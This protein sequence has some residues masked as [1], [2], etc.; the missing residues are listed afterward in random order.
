MRTLAAAIALVFL[1][2]SSS[3]SAEPAFVP[4]AAPENALWERLAGLTLSGHPERGLQFEFSHSTALGDGK[5]R[6]GRF[7]V[8]TT[9]HSTAAI[10]LG[11]AAQPVFAHL[12]WHLLILNSAGDWRFHDRTGWGFVLDERHT[13]EPFDARISKGH[14]QPVVSCNLG[15]WITAFLGQPKRF[16]WDEASRSLTIHGD[17][18]RRTVAWFRTPND[19]E[20][21]GA[22]LGGL[23]LIESPTADHESTMH[24]A[25]IQTQSGASRLAVTPSAELVTQLNATPF[26]A[27]DLPTIEQAEISAK[28]LRAAADF[29]ELV[30][31]RTVV[32]DLSNVGERERKTELEK[33][34]R[35]LSLPEQVVLLL[36]MNNDSRKPEIT[37]RLTR[38]TLLLLQGKI[39]ERSQQQ[40]VLY[41]DDPA[42]IRA[43]VE[44]IL[45]H[46][47]AETLYLVCNDLLKNP[48]VSVSSKLQICS[49]L[50]EWGLPVW[51]TPHLAFKDARERSPL[52][53]GLLRA[54]WLLPCQADHVAALER[55]TREPASTASLEAA[56]DALVRLGAIDHIGPSAF[57]WWF[58][59]NFTGAPTMYRW[60]Q[61]SR[62]SATVAGRRTL[63]KRLQTDALPAAEETAMMDVLRH[64]AAAAAKRPDETFMSATELADILRV[65]K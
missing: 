33:L 34:I 20:R 4:A 48:Q 17:R 58:E 45:S 15:A 53:D 6:Q 46:R 21:Y 42:M 3:A 18:D 60:R 41:P 14:K 35:S 54:G 49:M 55:A 52:L 23:L 62:L 16:Q 50:S 26:A 13:D 24:V 22:A 63:I 5:V 37:A 32:T 25:R 27:D 57:A 64:R 59:L 29:A 19:A 56:V 39:A 40:Q 43:E 51:A 12:D 11:T 2:G 9:P 44:A 7:L 30:T 8:E 61:L 36:A 47:N 38:Q 10:M 1:F 31:G 65:L 28:R